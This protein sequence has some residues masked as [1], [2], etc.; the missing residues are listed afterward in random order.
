MRLS[1]YRKQLVFLMDLSV[2]AV[3]AV[4]LFLLSPVGNG[5]GGKDLGPL[6]MNLAVWYGCIIIFQIV[7]HTYDSLW[8]YAE[9]KEYLALLLGFGFGTLLYLLLTQMFFRRQLAGLYMVSTLGSSLILMLSIRFG[10][11][12]HRNRKGTKKRKDPCRRTAIIGAGDAGVLL[13]REILGKEE[14]SYQSVLL[15]DDDPERIGMKVYGVPVKGPIARLPKIVKESDIEELILAIP[16]CPIERRREIIDLCN[17]TGIHLQILP[18]RVSTLTTP[19]SLMGQMRDVQLEDLLGR[20]PIRLNGQGVEDMINGRTVMVTGGGGSIGSELCRQIASLHPERLIILDN[21][22]N[23]TYDLQQELIRQY[24][25]QLHLTVEIA[26]VQDKRLISQLF[27]QYRPQVIF[28]AAAHKHVPLMENSPAEA[29]KNNV[30]GTYNLVNAACDAGVEKF[31]LISTDKAVNPTS[32]MGA[33]K[34]ICEMILSSMRPVEKT[35]FVA[36]R[37]GNVLGS[38]G[39]VIPLF[40]KQIAQGGPVTITDKRI[41]RYFMTVQEAVTLVLQAGAMAKRSEVFVLDMGKPVRILDLAENLIRLSGYRPYQDIPIVEIGLRPGE[42]LYEEL[43]VG[44][45]NQK[46]TEH[47]LIFVEKVQAVTP[48]QMQEILMDLH[49]AVEF[50]AESEVLEA[51]HRSVP[52]YHCPEEVNKYFE[53]EKEKENLCAASF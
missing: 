30:F 50:G 39:S 21:Y 32:I 4:G 13:L 6:M 35:D 46:H 26:N 52:E 12:M 3:V 45:K 16:S 25:D 36:V 1:L 40:K 23:S 10:Y 49:Q 33:T 38:N 48:S 29:V 5:T 42:K 24:G 37:F 51:L 53:R 9:G 31:V 27:S 47:E 44:K 18:D 20:D 19:N 7:F 41:T 2:M 28:H 8:R 34:R 14:C 11:R 15:L 17:E 22:E 43:L